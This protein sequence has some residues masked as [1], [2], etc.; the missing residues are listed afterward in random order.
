MPYNNPS[1][2]TRFSF[3]AH[4]IIESLRSG[5]TSIDDGS[6]DKYI[7]PDTIQAISRVHWTP[8]S[9]ALKASQLLAG[10]EHDRILDI[11]SGVGKFCIVGGLY[12]KGKFHGVEQRENLYT[13]SKSIV[14]KFE[15]ENVGFTHS[16][17]DKVIFSD[18]NAFYFFNPFEENIYPNNRIDDTVSL[19]FAKYLQY[20]QYVRNEFEKLPLNTKIV[21]YCSNHEV[22]PSGYIQ[23]YHNSKERLSLWVK[24]HN[25][26]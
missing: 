16:N 5:F 14:E 22:I 21:T 3:N 11:G 26:I 2:L 10:N 7:Y 17:I 6:F 18:Y 12:T 8:V 4:Y 15:L 24:K 1:D 13:I 20:T 19:S 25:T 9:I 23:E